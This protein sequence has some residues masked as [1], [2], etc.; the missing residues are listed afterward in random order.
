M[1]KLL[2]LDEHSFAPVASHRRFEY[3]PYSS[4]LSSHTST[5]SAVD[6]TGSSHPLDSCLSP[7]KYLRNAG[8]RAYSR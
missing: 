6:P 3:N 1:L 7:S 5:T 2:N 4:P 8:E